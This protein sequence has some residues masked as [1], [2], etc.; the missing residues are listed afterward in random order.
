MGSNP[1]TVYKFLNDPGALGRASKTSIKRLL[2]MY[3]CIPQVPYY[4]NVLLVVIVK[5]I[6]SNSINIFI[7]Q[8]C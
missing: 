1:R 7:R 6:N 8:L 5:I 4:S 2:Y 3:I